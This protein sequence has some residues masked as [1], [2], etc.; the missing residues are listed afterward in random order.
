MSLLPSNEPAAV[1][2]Y[3]ARHATPD[4]TRTDLVY[5]LPPVNRIFPVERGYES[6]DE[7]L[8]ARFKNTPYVKKQKL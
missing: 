5:Y 4:W 8:K 6:L 1:T 7:D 2:L 3:L